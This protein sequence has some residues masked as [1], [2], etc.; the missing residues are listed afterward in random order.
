M[1]LF[2][3]LALVPARLSAALHAVVTPLHVAVVAPLQSSVVAP[4]HAAVVA[5]GGKPLPGIFHHLQGPLQHYGYLAVAGFL[6]FEDFGVP[7]PGETMLIAASLYAG[8]GHLNVWLVALI[9]FGAA[10]L[11]DNVGFAIGHFG[12]RELVERFGKYV[13]LTPKRIDHA[14]D[15]FNRHGGKVVTVARFIEGL[16]QLNGIIAGTVGMP[17][18]RFL[19]FNVIGAAL[20]VG[21]WTSLGY[22]AGNHVEAI[23][24]YF[25][26]VAGGVAALVVIAIV[27]RFLRRRRRTPASD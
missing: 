9:G 10:V 5:A 4:L 13:F 7:L 19:V 18:R 26:Y 3:L 20:W 22:L 24:H 25:T 23:S 27:I 16:R 17:W 14:E 2:P 1:S 8:T 12:G 15:F 21:V 11:G 6:F